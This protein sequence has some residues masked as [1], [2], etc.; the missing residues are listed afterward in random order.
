[1]L[2]YIFAC[3]MVVAGFVCGSRAG[4]QYIAKYR[5][6]TKNRKA[7]S[8]LLIISFICI[9][10]HFVCRFMQWELIAD[11]ALAAVMFCASALM[12]LARELATQ[13][14]RRTYS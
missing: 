2:Y 12:E 10:V 5:S 14:R 7:A 4:C 1:M 8:D 13:P 6:T 9:C 3:A 11:L